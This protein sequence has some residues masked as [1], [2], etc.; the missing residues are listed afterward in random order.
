MAPPVQLD[1]FDQRPSPA[2]PVQLTDESC[3]MTPV[4]EP[5]SVTA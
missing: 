5:I 2:A 4:V 1:G 3:V